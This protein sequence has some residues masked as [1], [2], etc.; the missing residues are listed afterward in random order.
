ML[1][2]RDGKAIVNRGFDSHS[3]R[4]FYAPALPHIRLFEFYREITE[5]LRDAPILREGCSA[6]FLYGSSH[7]LGALL[8]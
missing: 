6:I 7:E 8:V 3:L 1:V 5:E 4:H 2:A